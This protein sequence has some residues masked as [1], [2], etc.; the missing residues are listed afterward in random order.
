M[1]AVVH[2]NYESFEPAVVR[3]H[4]GQSV[5]WLW[6]IPP[7]PDNVDIPGVASSPAMQSG[8]WYHTFRVPGTY[9]YRSDFHQRMRATVVVEP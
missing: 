2:L 5:E 6:G 3:I 4:A 7:V 8:V 9:H 1:G